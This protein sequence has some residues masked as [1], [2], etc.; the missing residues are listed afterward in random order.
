MPHTDPTLA[1]AKQLI[2]QRSITPE[3]AQC[4]E[5][6]QTRLAPLGFHCERIDS[7]GVAN[8]WARRG[9]SAPVVCLAGH[10]D[11]V[12][13]GPVEQWLFDPFTPTEHEGQLYGRGAAD[14]K[15]SVAAFVTAV[16]RLIAKQPEHT[17]SI[18]FLITADEEGAATD[19]TIKVVQ[20]LKAR[21]EL[22]DYCI[23]G[24]PTSSQKFGDMLKNGRR[25]SLNG[26]LTI[27]GVQG[28]IAYPDLARN[29]IHQGAAA[30]AELA[31]I[32]WD[33]GDEYFPPSSFQISNIHA[34]T[35]ANNV[36]PGLMH[37]LFNIRFSSQQTEAGLKQRI[38]AVLDAHQL[39]YTLN[40]SLSGNPF[41]T[42]RGKLVDALSTSI[43][44][45][46][47]LTPALSTSGGTSDGR[48]IATICK[49]VVEFGPLNATIHKINECV[50]LEDIAPLSQIYEKTLETLLS[51]G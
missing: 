28:H 3:N 38:H 34:G 23:V 29:P 13:P 32:E 7:Q 44:Q 12:P 2:A 27:H 21:G 20:A 41:I 51:Q 24:E 18:A 11:V 40:W 35:G 14:M 19:G 22:L 30:L 6:I 39:D 17:G 26:E 37:L 15:T 9:S 8:L 36:I 45:T 33:K 49:E 46:V 31:A 10:I 50:A 25:G 5:I 16:E 48:F 42:A 47:G 43:E 4:L 1:L